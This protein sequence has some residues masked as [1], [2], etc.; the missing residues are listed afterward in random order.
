[1]RDDLESFITWALDEKNR[2][3]VK[4]GSSRKIAEQ[5]NLDTNSNITHIYVN[6]HRLRWIKIDG[7]LY[8]VTKLPPFILYSE[9]FKKYAKDN[10]MTIE[11]LD[12]SIKP[13][14]DPSTDQP[15][16]QPTDEPIVEEAN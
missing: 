1:M 2:R 11:T 13:D 4:N 15:T 3:F 7:L 9:S 8:D 6:N 14:D 10:K 16:N 12:W 5:Y